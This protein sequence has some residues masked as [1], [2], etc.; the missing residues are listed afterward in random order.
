MLSPWLY[1]NYH[2]ISPNAIT[3]VGQHFSESGHNFIH[4]QFIPF[5]QIKSKF[6]KFRFYIKKLESMLNRRM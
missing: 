1:N 6:N 4:L 5:E 2:T 3:T